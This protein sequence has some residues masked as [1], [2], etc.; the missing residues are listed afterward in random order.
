METSYQESFIS[1]DNIEEATHEVHD[2]VEEGLDDDVPYL[3]EL[4]A[5]EAVS[6]CHHDEEVKAGKEGPE[7]YE[8][9]KD[10]READIEK[11]MEDGAE[12]DLEDKK[13]QKGPLNQCFNKLAS[14]EA[15]LVRNFAH[16]PIYWLTAG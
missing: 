4:W 10:G 9:A 5:V 16:P 8:G 1:V 14:L 2:D 13:R 12:Q 3:H 7:D 6:L 15:T 11:A